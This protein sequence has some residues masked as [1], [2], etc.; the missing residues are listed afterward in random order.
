VTLALRDAGLVLFVGFGQS[1]DVGFS[2]SRVLPTLGVRAEAPLDPQM[3]LASARLLRPG[4]VCVAISYSGETKETIAAVQAA[5]NAGALV[6]ALTAFH[7]ST[8]TRVAAIALVTRTTGRGQLGRWEAGRATR[9]AFLA[10]L[11]ALFAGILTLEED[12]DGDTMTVAA[13]EA[14]RSAIR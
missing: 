8:L 14:Q 4:D 13:V 1:A 3:Q 11:D 9:F 7:G 12:A 2:S 6:I 5:A 10:V